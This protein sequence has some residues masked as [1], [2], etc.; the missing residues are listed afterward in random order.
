MR[1]RFLHEGCLEPGK[2]SGHP[3]GCPNPV[4]NARTAKYCACAQN[5]VNAHFWCSRWVIRGTY[6]SCPESDSRAH[7][8]SQDGVIHLFRTQ[9]AHETNSQG[10][11]PPLIQ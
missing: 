2:P 3:E 7:V 10:T 11:A 9:K 5:L 8:S 6:C 1:R 4:R